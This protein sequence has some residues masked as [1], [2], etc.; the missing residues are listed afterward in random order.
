MAAIFLVI[1][2]ERP[3]WNP[4]K[5]PFLF[6]LVDLNKPSNLRNLSV[7]RPRVVLSFPLLRRW[8]YANIK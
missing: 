8:L 7:A 2:Y 3:T 6:T 4:S 1:G 5:V